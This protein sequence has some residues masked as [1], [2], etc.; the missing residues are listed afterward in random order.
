MKNEAQFF[1]IASRIQNALSNK[2]HYSTREDI[3]N[4][5]VL[6]RQD[7]SLYYWKYSSCKRFSRENTEM[8]IMIR[9]WEDH[10]KVKKCSE[11]LIV[12]NNLLQS[13]LLEV[14]TPG[15]LQ[16]SNNFFNELG[17]SITIEKV[18]SCNSK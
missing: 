12:I 2:V 7:L 9:V 10:K 8:R 15:Q 16:G 11:K 17:L 3:E 5:S 14:P 1:R 18:P 4:R 13:C 6:P